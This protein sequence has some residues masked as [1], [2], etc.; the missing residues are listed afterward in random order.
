MMRRFLIRLIVFFF[1]IF[2]VICILSGLAYTSGES[3]DYNQIIETQIAK[4]YTQYGPYDG[5][6]LL[7]YKLQAINHYQPEVVILGSSRVLHYRSAF[8]K[9]NVMVYNASSYGWGL[10]RYKTILHHLATSE[11]PPEVVIIGLDQ[12]RF[13]ENWKLQR[14]EAAIAEASTPVRYWQAIGHVTN[15]MIGEGATLK[16][17]VDVVV[18]HNKQQGVLGISAILGTGGYIYDGSFQIAP[19]LWA[20]AQS[21]IQIVAEGI[22]QADE[23]MFKYFPYAEGLATSSFETL[24]DILQIAS[25]SNIYVIGY[26][27]PFPPTIYV[28][29]QT[30][31]NFA[32]VDE[33]AA[34]LEAVFED[35]GFSFFDFTDGS[36]LGG[37]DAEFWD[38]LHPTEQHMIRIHLKLASELPGLIGL[39]TDEGHLKQ[40]LAE[41]DN[42]AYVFTIDNHRP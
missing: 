39:K 36:R 16:S 31:G 6:R 34:Q 38:S 35:F 23:K 24:Q 8:F 26:F 33:A 12:W 27:S 14:D 25:D 1:P 30:S 19:K 42:P 40:I 2:L 9:E 20:K 29:M 4:P 37:S 15:A 21:N 28:A 7:P 17:L 10:N 11:T 3:W 32:Y 18:P 41:N 13:Q 22:V 5:N